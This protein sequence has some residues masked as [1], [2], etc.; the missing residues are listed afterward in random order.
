M[1]IWKT[2]PKGG[3]TP[4]PMKN[5]LKDRALWNASIP[6]LSIVPLLQHKGSPAT[7][8]V[9]PRETVR[10]GMLI[11]RADSF[12]GAHVHSPVP[13]TV[14]YIEEI[15]LPWGDKT[16]AVFIELGGEFNRLGKPVYT[17]PWD[18][19]RA[20]RLLSILADKGLVGMG[21]GI[22]VHR[23]LTIPE[24]RTVKTLIIN[25]IEC[26][27]YLCADYRIMVEKP[28]E[29][30]SGAR[31]AAEITRP[32]RTII[33]L[34][35]D[36]KD[37]VGALRKK[38]KELKVDIEVRSLWP[39][40]PQ[41]DEKQ[42]IK[43]L[44]GEEITPRGTALDAGAVVL[45]VGTTLSIY[46]AVVLQKPLVEKTITVAG[47]ALMKQANLKVRIGTPLSDLVEECGGFVQMPQK[48]VV[49]GPM[50]GWGVSELSAPI[51]KTTSG[52]LFLS[53]KEVHDSRKTN[54]LNCGR[55][56][57]SCPMGL[58][59][60]ALYKWVEHSAYEEARGEGLL[61]CCECGCCA[62]TCPAQL[63]LMREIR[64]GKM[65]LQSGEEV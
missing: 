61:D 56:L 55:C 22:P 26:E 24:G 64:A 32:G 57:R 51:T 36:R 50:T 14:K 19:L 34:S 27:P 60:S 38:I 35:S 6:P 62:Y 21:S 52:V 29:L 33:A 18:G 15:T 5:R 1:N 11:G 63:P 16:P 10:E 12:N 3:L 65:I 7:C 43:V 8:L 25:G 30:I 47:R 45:N 49:G 39:K 13:G 17:H 23:K 40:Y 44:C 48:I 41:G 53:A 2:F 20:D 46:E 37:A 28:E 4:L 9:H 59:P 31:I 58:Q 42:L 54:C